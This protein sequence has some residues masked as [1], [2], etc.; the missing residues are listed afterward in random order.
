MIETLYKCAY[1]G[2]IKKE[3]FGRAF[4]SKEKREVVIRDA[5]NRRTKA[6]ITEDKTPDDCKYTMY[7][8][9]GI[10][11]GRIWLVKQPSNKIFVRSLRTDY[12]H[13]KGIGTELIKSGIQRSIDEGMKG[14]LTLYAANYYK[15]VGYYRKSNSPVP[16]YYKLGFRAETEEANVLIKNGMKNL[17]RNNFYDGP[18]EAYMILDEKSAKKLLGNK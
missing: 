15:S 10:E 2:T 6:V 12:A 13:Y 11:I 14:E 9:E 5:Y 8:D 17:E 1:E 4:S 16:F 7:N 3:T 18:A